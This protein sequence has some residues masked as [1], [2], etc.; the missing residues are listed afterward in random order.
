M[1]YIYVRMCIRRYTQIQSMDDFFS[2]ECPHCAGTVIVGRTELNCQIFRHG[3]LKATGQPIP[4]HA[5]KTECDQLRSAG[6]I[7][8][9]GKPFTFNGSVAAVCDYI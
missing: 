8:G 5:P 1:N 7:H 2:F 4:P 9:C 3:V 6:L